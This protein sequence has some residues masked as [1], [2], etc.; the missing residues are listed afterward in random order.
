M[1]LL[2]AHVDPFVRLGYLVLLFAIVAVVV[3]PTSPPVLAFVPLAA[4]FGW[5][6]TGG[7]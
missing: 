4:F 5:L 6:N 1:D 7:L 2:H 3:L